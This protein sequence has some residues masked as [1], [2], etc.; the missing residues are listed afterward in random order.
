MHRHCWEQEGQLEFVHGFGFLC[1]W[2]FSSFPYLLAT[3][4]LS[5]GECCSRLWPHQNPPMLCSSD[6]RASFVLQDTGLKGDLWNPVCFN[7]F[8]MSVDKCSSLCW[9]L[10]LWLYLERFLGII[11]VYREGNW[12]RGCF[13]FAATAFISDLRLLCKHQMSLWVRITLSL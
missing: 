12:R 1:C 3:W 2:D 8:S 5:A 13:W 9:V 11:K 4:V 6:W 10:Q 7:Q